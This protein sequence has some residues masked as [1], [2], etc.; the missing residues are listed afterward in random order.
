MKK[1]LLTVKRNSFI[2]KARKPCGEKI[3]REGSIILEYL[4]GS[5]GIFVVIDAEQKIILINR[6]GCEILGYEEEQIIGKNWFDYFIEE[7]GCKKFKSDF[8][9]VVLKKIIPFE[10]FENRIITKNGKL[11]DISWHISLIKDEIGNISAVICS[12]E[13]ITSR[14]I[15]DQKMI[16]SKLKE[17]E[18]KYSQIAEIIQE[19]LWVIDS[20]SIITYTNLR[21]TKILG[22]SKQ[23][24]I[25][26]SVFPFI[27][28][29]NFEGYK[30]KIMNQCRR[31]LNFELLKKD[32][33]KIYTNLTISPILNFNGKYLGAIFVLEDVSEHKNIEEKLRESEA[34]YR[35]IFENTGTAMTII[36]PDSTILM[37]NEKLIKSFG[38]SR[39]EIEGKKWTEF[40]HRG[41][42]DKMLDNNCL[43]RIDLA[44]P[45]RTY[46][47]R[48]IDKSGNNRDVLITNALI[49]WTD[50]IICS[51]MDI[52][53]RKSAEEKVKGSLKEK[54]MLLR[55]IHHRV[56]NNMQVVLSLLRLQSE[57]NNN[58]KCEIT[59]NEIQNRIK[60]MI[61]IH[62]KL[63]ES[64]DLAKICFADYIR[65]LCKELFHSYGYSPS[66][67]SLDIE[68]DDIALGIDAAIPI[69]LIINELVSNSFKYAFTDRINGKIKIGFYHVNDFY[70][71]LEVSDNG[72]GLPENFDFKKTKTLGLHLVNTLVKQLN[73]EIELDRTEGTKFRIRFKRK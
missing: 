28:E 53:E 2:K 14:D 72:L 37:V 5:R 18:S 48:F 70:T 38:Y 50:R 68:A 62:E 44:T 9:K 46:E 10:N 11:W 19:G 45:P 31:V 51:M 49:P 16:E 7:Q 64:K 13:D 43:R 54:E 8:N 63:Y 25:G 35:T 59:F 17:S 65:S 69:A 21:M 34:K 61:L 40:L 12:G 52:T 39:E 22:F 30:V 15:T 73:G 58:E 3:N 71:E 60:S 42:V 32:G 56:K 66:K 20:K 41:D 27:R 55:E 67:I 29:Q 6:R 57:Y 33:R 26:K 1:A 36:D 47:T 24:M 4:L 23:E